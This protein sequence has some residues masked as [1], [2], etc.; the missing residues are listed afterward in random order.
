MAADDPR[1]GHDRRPV[2]SDVLPC[3]ARDDMA[4]R[5]LRHAIFSGQGSIGNSRRRPDP[6]LADLGSGEPRQAVALAAWIALGA[7]TLLARAPALGVTVSH[8]VLRRAFPEVAAPQSQDAVHLIEA[9]VVITAACPVIAGVQRL[10]SRCERASERLLKRE[11][12]C[13]GAA[14]RAIPVTT[15]SELAVALAGEASAP[16]P[17]PVRG[18]GTVNIPGVPFGVSTKFVGRHRRLRSFGVAERGVSS[19]SLRP[20]YQVTGVSDGC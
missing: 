8:V 1:D 16:R 11:F 2:S 6:H 13:S 19:A 10:H 5:P 20:F 4:Y 3:P 9:L 7:I 17:A 12:V 14:P 15:D 18:G